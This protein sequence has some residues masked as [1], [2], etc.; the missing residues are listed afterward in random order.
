MIR[1]CSASDCVLPRTVVEPSAPVV[2]SPS[3]AVAAMIGKP[4]SAIS[5]IESGEIGLSIELLRS[6]ITQFGGELQLTAI[7]ND[8]QVLLD[9]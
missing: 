9:A 7:F 5:Q 8:R 4:Q 3:D 1:R 6:I 2:A